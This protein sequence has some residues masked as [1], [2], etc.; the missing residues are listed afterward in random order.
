M[1]IGKPKLFSKYKMKSKLKQWE[2][3][4]WPN[5]QPPVLIGIV[6]AKCKKDAMKL[7]VKMMREELKRHNIKVTVKEEDITIV[8][9]TE[10]TPIKRWN[11]V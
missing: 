6:N 3:S 8:L 5:N 4:M 9:N 11:K 1:D 2:A 10:D 7:V